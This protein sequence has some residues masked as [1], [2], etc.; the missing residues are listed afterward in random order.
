MAVVAGLEMLMETQ[1]KGCRISL[2]HQGGLPLALSGD[3]LVGL[4]ETHSTNRRKAEWLL[5]IVPLPLQN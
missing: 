3:P 2:L 1:H 5:I 4:W